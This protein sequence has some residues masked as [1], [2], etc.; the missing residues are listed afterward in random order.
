[1]KSE[2]IAID[3][4]AGTGKTTSAALVAERL[5]F[6]YVDSGAVYRA[7]ALALHG[8]G[9]RRADDPALAEALGRLALR[10][11]PTPTAFRVF[12]G[13]R[14]L[15]LELRSPEISH[16]SSALAVRSEVRERVTEL[17]R[18]AASLGHLVVEG[19]DIGTVVFP[20]AT[21]KVFLQA[22]LMVRARR[23]RLDLARQGREQSEEQVARDLAERDQRDSSRSE[24]P[25]RRAPDA[26]LV[27]TSATDIEGQVQQI[28]D[29][30]RRA[31]AREEGTDRP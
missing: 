12:L 21:L 18:A 15:G 31:R 27:D 23:R 10:I 16:L 1:M 3:G 29:A 24:A 28:L 30:Y 20:D 26:L 2:I 5:G 17:L 25:L 14:E 9:I 19:R 13:P 8:A 6:C 11:E 7:V 22:E 4:G